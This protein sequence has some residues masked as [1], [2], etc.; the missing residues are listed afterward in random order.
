MGLVLEA[1]MPENVVH[2]MKEALVNQRN[3]LDNSSLGRVPVKTEAGSQ[4]SFS[5]SI[6]QTLTRR[7]EHPVMRPMSFHMLDETRTSRRF[8]Q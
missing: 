6:T 7:L 4:E 3:L 1:Q 5:H 8:S 2:Q